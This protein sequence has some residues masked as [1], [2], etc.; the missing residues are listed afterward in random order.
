VRS[1]AILSLVL[2]ATG[3][4]HEPD[5]DLDGDAV[6]FVYTPPSEAVVSRD[7]TVASDDPHARE[8]AA[9]LMPPSPKDRPPPD[10]IPFRIGAGHGALGMVDL[11][12]CQQAGLDP[13][14]VHLRVTFH[15][16]GRVVH[17]VVESPTPPPPA[18]LDCVGEQLQAAAVPSFD[19]RDATLSKSIFVVP[20]GAPQD[21]I[22][23][24]APAAHPILSV[25]APTTPKP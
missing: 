12:P 20:G 7:I 24:K 8:T 14:Y 6:G 3:C 17:A 1:I 2:F 16:N 25:A 10:P 23:R 9:A 18:A 19:G 21:V 13:G 4:L 15:R 5:A 11:E 22:V